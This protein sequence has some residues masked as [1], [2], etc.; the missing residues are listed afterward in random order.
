MAR[1]SLFF[2]RRLWALLY[3][4]VPLVTGGAACLVARGTALSFVA[5]FCHGPMVFYLV[6]GVFGF[7]VVARGNWFVELSKLFIW[8]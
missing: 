8:Q 4:G 6:F 1:Q 5:S 2:S 7:G 3:N